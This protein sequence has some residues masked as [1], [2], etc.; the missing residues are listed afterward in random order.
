MAK[1]KTEAASAANS[2]GG[3]SFLDF[4]KKLSKIPGFELGSVIEHNTFSE[5]SEYINTGNYLLNAV[6]SGSLLGGIPNSRSLGLVGDPETGKTY[7]CLNFVREFQKANYDCIYCETEAAVDRVTVKKFGIDTMRMRYQPIKTVNEFKI[8]TMQVI[9]GVQEAREAGHNPKIALFLDSLGMLSTEKEINDA[10]EGKTAMDMGLKAKQLR[11][12]FRAITL[13]LAAN[14]IP[15]IC[16]NHTTI[17][18][19]GSYTGPTKESAGGDGPIFAMSS[20]LFMSKK[21]ETEGVDKVK[22]GVILNVRPRKSRNVIPKNISMHVSF[23][24]GMNPYVGLEEYVNWEACGIDRGKIYT[25]K[26]A[27]KEGVKNG[28]PFTY[29]YDD[30]DKETGE[31]KKTITEELVFVQ[32]DTGRWCVKHLGKSLSS[33]SQLFNKLVFTHEVI[34]QLDENV[35]QNEFKFPDHVDSEDLTEFDKQIDTE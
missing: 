35:I 19:I 1:K 4:D 28:H 25:K 13:D 16:T 15:L 22:T 3:F 24:G 26:E 27:E 7:L 12:M 17:G 14:K 32:K 18:G 31:I 21:F 20:L 30:V 10:L 11:A 34:K 23:V 5:V 9:K 29:T 2:G 8:F 6:L 33:G